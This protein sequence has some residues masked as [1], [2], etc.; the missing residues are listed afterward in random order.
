VKKVFPI[1]AIALGL[2]LSLVLTLFA[3]GLDVPRSLGLIFDGALGNRFGLATA[4]VR[5]TP[6]VLAGLGMV[7]AWRAGMFNIGGEGQYM[8]GALGGA[9]IAQILIPIAP[10]PVV[11]IA[12]LLVGTVFGALF[13]AFAGW[14]Q[15]SRGVQVVISTILL[16]FVAF[17]VVNWAIRGPL[18]EAK[19]QL[20]QT[21][22][23]PDAV[24][25][26][27]FDPQTSLHSGVIFP[28]IAVGVV[29]VF[30]FVSKAGLKLR[31]VGDNQDAGKA[32]QLPTGRIQI[33][34]MAWSGGLCGLAGTIDYV[35]LVGHLGSGHAQNWGFLA[36]PVALLGG[37]H[38]VGT[39]LSGLYFGVLFAGSENL[40]R[41]TP[42]GTTIV[43]VIQAV[44]VLSFVAF[45]RLAGE[46]VKRTSA[47]KVALAGSPREGVE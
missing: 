24:M 16:N 13:A 32:N 25:M 28:L 18:Q 43:Y 9:W 10:A 2:V 41:F 11:N 22:S 7:V 39:L 37:L 35:G 12:I 34:A 23:L 42:I 14:L 47:K 33:S 1:L 21:Q 8:M 4:L 36:I 38:P 30:L 19:R 5:S 40:A 45:P 6:L 26:M 31:F 27:R 15:V 44:A 46:W 3:F 20:P 29:W 17:E